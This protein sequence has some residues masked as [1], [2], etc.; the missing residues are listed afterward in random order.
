MNIIAKCSRIAVPVAVAAA[1]TGLG[2]ADPAAAAG[3]IPDVTGLTATADP[4]TAVVTVTWDPYSSFG[5]GANPR[6]DAV[7][8]GGTVSGTGDTCGT[9]LAAGATG[10]QFTATATATYHVTVTPLTDTDSATGVAVDV[11]V[12]LTA[13]SGAVGSLTGSAD[14]VTNVV[15][16]SW[17][18]ATVTWGTGTGPVLNV[19]VSGL[20]SASTCAALM[21]P[22]STGCQFTATS[23]TTYTITVTPHNSAGDGTAGSVDVPVLLAPTAP[24]GAVGDLAAVYDAGAGLVTVSWTSGA[25]A[26][27]TG[28]N[29]GFAVSI[30]GGVIATDASDTC[31]GL[32][33]AATSCRFAP[34]Q[35]ATYDIAVT[36]VNDAGP[37]TRASI[38]IAVTVADPAATATAEAVIAGPNSV[39]GAAL[40]ATARPVVPAALLGLIL[41]LS[42]AGLRLSV[43]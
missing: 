26:W 37:G 21:P 24:N 25:V 19:S 20:P 16:V 14:P 34:E 3:T 9:G 35:T 2:I 30:T 12:T 22:N 38:P 11:P 15:T 31:T 13:P 32:T 17:D 1:V 43:R 5:A 23:T 7:V 33:P 39:A 42:G 29:R 4:A 36:P 10:C 28:A 18:P 41:L 27:G 8:T 6:I 40:A